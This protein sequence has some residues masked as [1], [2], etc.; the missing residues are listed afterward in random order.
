MYLCLVVYN[1]CI[2]LNI[3]WKKKYFCTLNILD[4][5]RDFRNRY[6][7]Y[8]SYKQYYVSEQK[9]G[10]YLYKEFYAVIFY[11][12]VFLHVQFV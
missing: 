12:K 9:I 1:L 4:D 5:Q 2:N 8:I 10:L 7:S 6:I 11:M 3:S